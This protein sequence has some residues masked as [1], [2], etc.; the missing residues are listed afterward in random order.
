MLNRVKG[1]LFGTAAQMSE[2]DLAKYDRLF[3]EGEEVLAGFK[4]IRDSF[5]FTNRRLIIEDV[6]GVTGRKREYLSI[7]YS[8]IS[9]FSVESA[10]HFDMDAELKIWVSGLPVPVSKKFDK[11]TDIYQIQAII[12]ANS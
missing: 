7:P 1:A 8:K 6:Q 3:F 9:G 12:A 4:V 10:G 2:E 11:N 5:V